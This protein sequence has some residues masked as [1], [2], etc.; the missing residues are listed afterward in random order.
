MLY[1]GNCQ[2]WNLQRAM[3]MNTDVQPF[4]TLIADDTHDSR[5]LLIRLL[6]QFARTNVVEV[7]NGTEAVA[8]FRSHSPGLVFL[9]VDMPELDGISALREIRLINS[10]AFCVIVTGISSTKNV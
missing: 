10:N 6:Q 1:E 2:A 5:Q 4:T 9:D 3:P 7:R 8:A